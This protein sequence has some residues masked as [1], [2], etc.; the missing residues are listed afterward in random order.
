MSQSDNDHTSQGR[1]DP[2]ILA[3]Q[4]ACLLYFKRYRRL[5]ALPVGWTERCET[6]PD[7][8]HQLFLTNGQYYVKFYPGDTDVE[9]RAYINRPDGPPPDE[10]EVLVLFRQLFGDELNPQPG[11]HYVMP[12]GVVDFMVVCDHPTDPASPEP[13]DN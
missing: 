4:E 10:E 5:Y 11:S 2:E 9:P 7:G 13:S 6:Y 12:E 1:C 8:S 3:L